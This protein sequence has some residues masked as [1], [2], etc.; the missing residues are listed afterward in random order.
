M[1]TI[2]ELY[3]SVDISRPIEFEDFDIFPMEE[4]YPALKHV[5]PVHKRNFHMI[6]LLKDLR[7][8][9][10]VINDTNYTHKDSILFFLGP[11]HIFGSLRGSN[12]TTGYIISFSPTF[13]S[14]Y[15][16]DPSFE[17]SVFDAIHNNLFELSPEDE[18]EL[19]RLFS[20]LYR[21]RKNRDVAGHLLMAILAKS[22]ILQ[23]TYGAL[24][25]STST[26]FELVKKFKKLIGHHV[27]NN[28][29][30]EFYASHLNITPNY[31][32]ERIKSLTGKTAKALITERLLLEAK[33]L[34]K[35]SSLNVASIAYEL[36]FSDTAYFGRFFKKQTGTTPGKYRGQV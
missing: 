32:N 30:V 5:V 34:L 16:K 26:E 33:T 6:F 21:E 10:F 36:G 31:L 27:I 15:T 4:T 22:K 13:I 3:S 23:E 20:Y 11:E 12:D 25:Q 19:I 14:R 28:H 7:E 18:D 9:A 24:K 17:F 8:D 2:E 35:H 29:S 1:E